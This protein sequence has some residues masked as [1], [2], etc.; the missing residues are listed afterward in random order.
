MVREQS[1]EILMNVPV[2]VRKILNTLERSGYE[3]NLVGG[4]VRDSLMG[5]TPQDWDIA[6]SAEPAAVKSSLSGYYTIDTGIHHGTITVVADNMPIEVTTYRI[7]SGYSDGRHPDHVIFTTELEKDL[8]RRD[9][10]INAM[11]Y[12]NKGLIDPFYGLNDMRGKILRCVGEPEQRFRE[13]ALRIFR[14]LRFSACLG[15]S[16]E[17]KTFT[18]LLSQKDSLQNIAAERIWTEFRK[19]LTGKY[20]GKVIK[21][22]FPIFAVIFPELSR[23]SEGM[24]FLKIWERM[25][26]AIDRSERDLILRLAIFFFIWDTLQDSCPDLSISISQALRRLRCDT[27][28]LDCVCEVLRCRNLNLC[29]ETIALKKQMAVYGESCLRYVL[30]LH[31]AYQKSEPFQEIKQELDRILTSGECFQIGMLAVNGR[32]FEALGVRR[33]PEIGQIL[34]WLLENVMEEHCTN[35]KTALLQFFQNHREVFYHAE[36]SASIGTCI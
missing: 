24:S 12:G 8:A 2:P 18:A 31:Q 7:E 13:D 29:P 36:G 10:T 26:E 3:A 6:T 17:Q 34:R 23:N 9:F 30:A 4:C 28:S 35:E 21:K 19:L 27:K 11:A 25:G 1:H 20:A 33:G 14:G 16:I 22:T 5:L 32:D 15:F